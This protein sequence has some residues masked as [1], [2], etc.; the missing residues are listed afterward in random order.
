MNYYLYNNT[1]N[2]KSPFTTFISH[3]NSNHHTIYSSLFLFKKQWYSNSSLIFSTTSLIVPLLPLV[4]STDIN[5]NDHEENLYPLPEAPVAAPQSIICSTLIE[6][7][8]YVPP[9]II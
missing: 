9:E 5:N 4:S 6:T 1:N 8:P 3:N 7:L 2:W